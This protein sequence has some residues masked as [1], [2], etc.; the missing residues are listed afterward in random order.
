MFM[1]TPNRVGDKYYLTPNSPLTYNLEPNHWYPVLFE[2]LEF[3]LAMRFAAIWSRHGWLTLVSD[4][5]NGWMTYIGK[6]D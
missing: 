6:G 5:G 2:P 1:I 4:L 3:Y